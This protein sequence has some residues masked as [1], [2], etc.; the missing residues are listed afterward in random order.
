M[1]GVEVFLGRV[2]VVDVR[3]GFVE[4]LLE[5]V[6]THVVLH[7]GHHVDHHRGI[8]ATRGHEPAAIGEAAVRQ[9]HA[10]ALA[11]G[12]HGQHALAV[13]GQQR[14]VGEAI[15]VVVHKGAAVKKGAVARSLHGSVPLLLIT[16]VISCD[17]NHVSHVVGSHLMA[18][19]AN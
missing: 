3:H 1:Q 19:R 18:R 13:K 16:S 2:S 5:S 17:F 10:V 8:H 9:Q 6:P 4:Q 14:V 12:Q 15:A 7:G 11:G